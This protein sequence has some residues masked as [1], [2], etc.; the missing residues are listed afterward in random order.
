MFANDMNAELSVWNNS[1]LSSDGTLKLKGYTVQ[2]IGQYPWVISEEKVSLTP[3]LGLGLTD[4]SASWSHAAWW[5][6]GWSSPADYE[7]YGNGSTKARNG[8]SR[9][10]LPEDPSAAFTYTLGLVV[11]V[12]SHLDIDFFYRVVDLD[13]IDT[14][15]RVRSPSGPLRIRGAFPAKFSAYGVA[16]KYVF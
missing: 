1:G 3:Y 15:F 6:Y 13:D 5:H 10:M 16:L 14:N 4:V 9:W 8:Y 11:Q 12:Y 7:Q 2:A